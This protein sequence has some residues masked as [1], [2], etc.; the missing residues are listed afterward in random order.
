M[1]NALLTLFVVA[2]LAC[3][4]VASLTP[5]AARQSSPA[6]AEPTQRES[7]CTQVTQARACWRRSSIPQSIFLR[8]PSP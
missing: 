2:L 3:V 8:S 7:V 6:S 5:E 4:G 1:R